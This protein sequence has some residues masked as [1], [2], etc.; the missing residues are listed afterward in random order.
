MDR[1]GLIVDIN[2]GLGQAIPQLAASAGASIPVKE[3]D[4]IIG[5]IRSSDLAELLQFKSLEAANKKKAA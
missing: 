1:P 5:V 3:G 4:Q 2:D